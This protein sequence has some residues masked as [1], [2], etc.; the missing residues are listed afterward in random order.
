MGQDP[1]MSDSDTRTMS[2]APLIGADRLR[3]LVDSAETPTVLDVRWTLAGP[4]GR[5]AYEAGH[6]PGACFVD[7]E[8]ELAAVPRPD[9]RGGRHPLPDPDA[10]AAA[11]RSHGVSR[12]VPV[13]VYDQCD[14]IAA[15]RAWWLLEHHGH[16]DVRVLD[17]GIDAWTASGGPVVREPTLPSVGDFVASPGPTRV[18]DA[19]DAARLAERGLLLDAR[20][21]ERY[22]GIAEPMDP[23]AGH[24]PG[25][26][27]AP[28]WENLRPD[29]R[30][31]PPGQL[32]R[33]FDSLGVGADTEVGVYCG[34]GVTAAHEVLA[35]RLL[36]VDAALYVGSWSD[37]VSDPTRPVATSER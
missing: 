17:G 23:V 11:M 18:L 37:W 31:Q 13:V 26:V 29:G 25:A 9:R 15:A 24:V 1:A 22:A 8:T 21:H 7:L 32:R 2:R 4:D 34:S 5:Q 10:F 35:L 14:G 27:N 19:A 36:G 20:A 6:V 28:T 30:F 3:E 33:R 16:P 12:H